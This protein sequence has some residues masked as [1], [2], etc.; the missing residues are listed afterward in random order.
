MKY[1]KGLEFFFGI[2][3]CDNK[4]TYIMKILGFKITNCPLDIKIYHYHTSDERSYIIKDR[5]STP[6]LL[7]K[8]YLLNDDNNCISYK[9]N[10]NKLKKHTFNDNEK[11]YNYLTNKITNNKI[12]IIPMQSFIENNISMYT[13]ILNL[14][15]EKK[16]KQ[17]NIFSIYN[18][19]YS[20]IMKDEYNVLLKNEEELLLYTKLYIDAFNNCDLYLN[21]SPKT[22][23]FNK[24]NK[25]INIFENIIKKD[26]ITSY[27]TNISNF[28]LNN[29]WTTALKNKKI[30][31]ISPYVE[32]FK[33][34]ETYYNKI[35]DCN[36]FPN[37]DFI[38]LNPF[39]LN[40]DTEN[41]KTELT[42]LE[43]LN[44][45]SCK[46]M[47]IKNNFDIALIDSKGYNN[48]ICNEIFKLGKSVICIGE[49]LPM[50]FGIYNDKLLNE[51]KDNILI[52]NNRYWT[53]I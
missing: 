27:T 22:K 9:E 33:E 14:K 50:Y 10:N 17:Y 38:Y 40:K 46:I 2:P 25:F 51:Y 48:I 1:R 29:P 37:C 12:F 16:N 52:Y 20:N 41:I 30:L 18:H 11:L 8:P 31:L 28:I 32:L 23:Q 4:I 43:N 6:Y 24:F 15:N 7:I 35:Y 47:E 21:I 5:I 34:K 49:V 53:K 3:G 26:N 44:I 45:L 42:F 39:S 13:Y 19:K 36:L